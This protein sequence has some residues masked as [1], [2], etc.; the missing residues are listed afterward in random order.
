MDGLADTPL[1]RRIDIKPENLDAFLAGY[2]PKTVV[3]E[4]QFT[5]TSR[6]RNLTQ[7]EYR[8]VEIVVYSRSGRDVS[9]WAAKPDDQEILVPAGTKFKVLQAKR[10]NGSAQIELTEVGDD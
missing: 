1:Y 3:T 6:K 5:S 9:P 8:N 7:Y 10:Q 4:R 2:I